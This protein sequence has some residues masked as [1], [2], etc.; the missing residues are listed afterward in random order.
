MNIEVPFED[1][2]GKGGR[3]YLDGL[4]LREPYGGHLRSALRILDALGEQIAREQAAIRQELKSDERA[5]LLMSA[6]GIA[7]LTAGLILYEAGPIERFASDKAFVSYCC[8]APQTERSANWIGRPGVGRAG[9][10]Y[11]KEAFT[12]AAISAI[13]QDA[14]IRVFYNRMLRHAGAKKAK[15]AAARKLAVAVYHMLSRRQPYRPAP[16]AKKQ[17]SGKPVSRPGRPLETV[18]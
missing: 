16:C 9:N 2:F 17:M 7:E 18:A 4:T 12:Q 14:A 5:E 10:L 3:A 6:P 11:L 13:R 8:L 15:V 1:A